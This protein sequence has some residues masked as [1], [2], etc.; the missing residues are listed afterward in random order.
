MPE[1]RI[2]I[3]EITHPENQIPRHSERT[4]VECNIHHT[5]GLDTVVSLAEDLRM[6]VALNLEINRD[7]LRA[8]VFETRQASQTPGQW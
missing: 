2:V 7:T 8:T 6:A 4:I 5:D 1:Y 3:D